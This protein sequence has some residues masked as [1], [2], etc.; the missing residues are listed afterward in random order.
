MKHPT[1]PNRYDRWKVQTDALHQAYVQALL[2]IIATGVLPDDQV[3]SFVQTALDGIIP[4]D[5]S[6]Q[7]Y[8]QR[9]WETLDVPVYY[10]LILSSQNS[11]GFVHECLCRYFVYA[12]DKEN[13]LKLQQSISE[14][15][16]KISDCN[17][18]WQLCAHLY[19]RRIL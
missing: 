9:P 12:G 11:M 2:S 7:P 14:K 1:S 13:M 3:A 17:P 8:A 4:F 10:V 16:M 18:L 6:W 5:Q 19:T 15:D